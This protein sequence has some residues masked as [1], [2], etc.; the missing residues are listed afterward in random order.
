VSHGDYFPSAPATC[1]NEEADSDAEERDN[2]QV[3]EF[4][5]KEFKDSFRAVEVVKR[6]IM[7]A[8]PNFDRSMQIRRDVI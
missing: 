2:V 8:D 6:R 1:Q 7:D 3:R 5:L 4:S